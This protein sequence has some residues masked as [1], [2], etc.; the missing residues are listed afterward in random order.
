MTNIEAKEHVWLQFRQAVMPEPQIENHR[1]R[2]SLQRAHNLGYVGEIGE[3]AY[4]V[5]AG[6]FQGAGTGRYLGVRWAELR[7]LCQAQTHYETQHANHR[8]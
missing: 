3:L 1:V 2:S 5:K 4:D 8:P 6:F 7:C